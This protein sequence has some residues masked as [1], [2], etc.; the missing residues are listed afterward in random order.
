MK[1]PPAFLNDAYQGAVR[2]AMQE[3]LSQTRS[4]MSRVRAWKH[5]L[6][7]PRI[8]FRS[9]R[10]GLIPKNK[11]RERFASFADGQWIALLRQGQAAAEAHKAGV[12][13]R[14]HRQVDSV[15]K[16]A[17][18]A[19]AL[20]ELGELSSARQALEGATCA[21]GD[22]TTR[23][24]LTNLA[25]RLPEL[26]SELWQ[27]AEE[28]VRAEVPV[29]VVQGIRFGRM[30]A[31]PKPSGGVRGIVVGDTFRRAV[32]RAVAQH[33]AESVERATAPFQYALSTRSGTE[34]VAHAIQALTD[35]DPDSTVLSIDGIGAFDLVSR[36]A[37]HSGL[38]SMEGGDTLL[39]FVSQFYGQPS[40]NLWEDDEGVCHTIPQ[41]EGENKATP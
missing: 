36:E 38:P 33:V 39:P 18:R 20:V 22:D 34:C 24:A 27:M 14:R 19:H 35:F 28:F 29:E 21:P 9:G 7:L 11:L 31:L 8:L 26:R 23:A 13:R 6:L 5:F 12:L 10:G 2:L 17:E 41:G 16:R 25:R 4:E 37:M 3:T 40:Q 15:E 1:K 30:T 32:S